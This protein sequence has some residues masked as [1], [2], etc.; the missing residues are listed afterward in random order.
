MAKVVRFH[1]VGGPEV[2]RIDEVPVRALKAGEVSIKVG[3]IGLNRVE[4]MFRSGSF[5]VPSLPARIGYEAAGVIDAVGAGVSGFEV[6]ERV[7]TLP[8]LSMEEY[9]TNADTILYPADMLLPVPDNLSTAAAA[10]AWMQY[11][12]AYA[13]IGVAHIE[14]GDTVLITAASSSV[15][16]AAIQIVNAAGGV[17]IAVTRGRNKEAALRHHGA[18]HVI[19]SDEEDLVARAMAITDRRGVNI[20]FDAVAGDTLVDLVGLAA[21]RAI[22]IVYGALGGEFV[23][24]PG[25][26]FMLKSL[27]IRGFAMN[28]LMVDPAIRRQAVDYIFTGLRSG[29]LQP[30]IDRTFA[31]ADIVNAHRYLESNRQVGKIV[32]TVD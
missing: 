21:Q 15:G 25:Q 26:P 29:V 4:A 31:F 6:G 2:L 27:T 23:P 7:A 24:V 30:V 1:S 20:I 10:A 3:A 13:L 18:Q 28:D 12:T 14:R 11:L 16:L 19:V 9:G 17:S 8:G 22:I 5:G 32:V